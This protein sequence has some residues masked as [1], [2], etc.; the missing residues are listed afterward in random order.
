MDVRAG[1]RLP[2]LKSALGEIRP[3]IAERR[4]EPRNGAPEPSEN[5]IPGAARDA[6]RNVHRHLRLVAEGAAGSCNNLLKGDMA[7]NV[8][9]RWILEL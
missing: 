1:M 5:R 8:W 6:E 3:Q 9:L 7:L 2:R 4:P